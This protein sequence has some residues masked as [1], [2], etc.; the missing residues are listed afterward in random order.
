MQRYFL[1]NKEGNNLIFFEQDLHHIKNVMR[2]RENDQIE[3]IWNEIIYLCKIDSISPF[4]LKV[5]KEEKTVKKNN[6]K[7]SVAVSLVQEQNLT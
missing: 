4:S 2:F 7:L 1:K 5:I 6:V 3:A